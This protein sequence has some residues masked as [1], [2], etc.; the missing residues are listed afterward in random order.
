MGSSY[1]APAGVAAGGASAGGELY[2]VYMG[3]SFA[4]LVS[5]G[6]LLLLFSPGG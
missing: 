4:G 3:S 1:L 5:D 6:V 2:V